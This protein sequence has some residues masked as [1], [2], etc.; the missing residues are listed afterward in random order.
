[1]PS[2]KRCSTPTHPKPSHRLDRCRSL[3]HRPMNCW[4]LD[5]MTTCARRYTT[6]RVK[7]L[8]FVLQLLLQ[9][10]VRPECKID[11]LLPDCSEINRNPGKCLMNVAV[12]VSAHNALFGF[13]YPVVLSIH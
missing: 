8:M 4:L 11:K 10:V 6:L 2:A 9:G 7:S 3:D 13:G 1:M 12:N 5:R